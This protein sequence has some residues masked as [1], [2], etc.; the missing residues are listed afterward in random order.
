MRVA[1]C[2]DER[3]FRDAAKDALHDY[4]N[5][6]RLEISIDEFSCGEDFLESEHRYDFV[7]LDYMMGG[8]TGLE[9]AR[10]M[11]KRNINCV[12]IFI[13]SYKDIVYESFEVDT[14][15]F[16]KKPLSINDLNK[17]LDDYFNRFGN[18]YPIVLTV[19][20]N[21]VIVRTNDIV[22][23]EADNKRCFVHLEDKS[24]PCSTTMA[25]VAQ[26]LPLSIF[27]Q[28]HKAFIANLNFIRTYGKSEVLFK[29]GAAA[30]FGRKYKAAFLEAFRT[31]VRGRMP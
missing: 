12:I 29:N 5:I 6:R 17:A 20:R 11:R 3:E 1:I 27:F 19:D 13:T 25:R 28:I 7:L 2:D 9:A 26:G 21:K 14:F 18:D 4:S 23:L 24:L 15:R 31:H 8:I 10:M 22:Y 16:L 30:P